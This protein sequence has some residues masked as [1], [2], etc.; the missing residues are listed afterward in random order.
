MLK[1][2][3][4]VA[5]CKPI[6]PHKTIEPKNTDAQGR[7]PSMMQPLVSYEGVYPRNRLPGEPLAPRPVPLAPG[8]WR[9]FRSRTK[10]R[11][12]QATQVK[13]VIMNGQAASRG[14]LGE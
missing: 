4:A 3:G 2:R 6:E 7:N 14:T 11:S 1:P 13:G 9:C 8:S 5:A 10:L 12:I